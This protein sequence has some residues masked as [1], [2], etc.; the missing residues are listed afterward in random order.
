MIGRQ[1]SNNRLRR[2][3]TKATSS[4][5]IP[6]G[7]TFQLHQCGS[8]NNRVGSIVIDKSH[9]R[10]PCWYQLPA[11]QKFVKREETI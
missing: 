4:R 1:G 8:L 9:V 11:F 10:H 3:S 2:P 5:L 6:S 7:S